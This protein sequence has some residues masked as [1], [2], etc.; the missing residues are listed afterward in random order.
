VSY[1]KSYV[2]LAGFIFGYY[3]IGPLVPKIREEV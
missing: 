3:V 2:Y 1:L